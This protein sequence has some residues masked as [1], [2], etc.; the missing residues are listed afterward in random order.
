MEGSKDLTMKR[1]KGIFR[2]DRNILY[3]DCAGGQTH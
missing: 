1:H 2:D 3:L